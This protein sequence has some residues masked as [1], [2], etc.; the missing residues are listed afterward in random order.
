MAEAGLEVTPVAGKNGVGSSVQ[1][2]LLTASV[3]LII[4][5]VG[6]ALRW[7]R[8]QYAEF[9]ADQA[10]VINRALDFVANG[11]FP[12][13]GIRSSVGTA[14]GPIEI[15][16]LSIPLLISTNPVVATGF[17]GLLQMLAVVGTFFL[18]GKYY[19]RTAGFVAA[20][21]F[22]V[23]PWALQYSR[24]MWT[25]DMMPF[26]TVLFAY[27]LHA[28]VID[29]KRYQAALAFLWFTVLFLI[30]PAAVIYG[31]V[32]LAVVVVYWRR[33]GWRPLLLGAVL[34]LI[35][36]SPYLY[37]ESQREFNSIAVY[38]GVGS[39]Q[40]GA[41]DLEAL[42]YVVTMASA[43]YYPVMMGYGFRGDWL[44]PEIG[45]SNDLA[46][47]LLY[48]GLALCLGHLAVRLV[49]R[50]GVGWGGAEKYLILLLWFILP[51]LAAMRHSVEFYPH[52]FIGVYP[53]QFLLIAVAVSEGGSLVNT[54]LR[55]L[56][57]KQE[58]V[59]AVG[60][61][62]I[63]LFIGGQQV[64]FF[65]TYVDLVERQGPLGPYGVPLLYSQKAV[66]T[67]RELRAE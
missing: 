53:L 36:A 66:D 11:D 62:A 46:T 41:L 23:N 47:W 16:L 43:R 28:A 24:K 18:T 29:R 31:P 67:L 65:H 10:W 22:A 14:Q 32:L 6:L 4:F 40:M 3:L 17:V 51:I 35:V 50:R 42:K 63:V 27:S 64:P 15:Y 1:S 60:A 52:Y 56:S 37:Y 57:F 48:L 13:A 59:G 44:L 49:R 33:I 39:A 30:H 19:G 25:P 55:R 12:Y 45:R 58:W 26:F 61:T 2:K 54:L 38:A 8:L 9:S 5:V 21:L 20:A 7:D 34:A